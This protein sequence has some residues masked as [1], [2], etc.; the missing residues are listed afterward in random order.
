M[1]D[2]TM[3]FSFVVI[4]GKLFGISAYRIKADEE[5]AAQTVSFAI[6][7]GDDI[8]IIIVLEILTVYFEYL[9][10]RTENIGDFTDFFS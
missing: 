5:V 8:R 6:I 9:L 10:V 2:D 1:Y 4:A 3:Q 7:K